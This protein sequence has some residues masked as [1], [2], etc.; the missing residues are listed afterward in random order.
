[1]QGQL[2]KC[3]SKPSSPNDCRDGAKSR[4]R[5]VTTKESQKFSDTKALRVRKLDA[6]LYGAAFGVGNEAHAA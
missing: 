3:G 1:M 2:R 6:Q 4:A 5:A